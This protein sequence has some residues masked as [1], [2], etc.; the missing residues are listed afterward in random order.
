M[1]ATVLA[2]LAVFAVAASSCENCSCAAPPSADVFLTDFNLFIKNGV[3]AD[4]GPHEV[5]ML[6]NQDY[7]DL[8][9]KNMKER[10]ERAR[11]AS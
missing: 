6:R 4:I 5:L 9:N 3:I 2:A 10:S 11:L 1:R 7:F 8:L